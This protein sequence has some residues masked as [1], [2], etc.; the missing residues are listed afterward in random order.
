MT[1]ELLTPATLG[2]PFR[3]AMGGTSNANEQQLDD[4]SNG[5]RRATRAEL[6]MGVSGDGESQQWKTMA[7]LGRNGDG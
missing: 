3:W 4:L 2:N 6:T 5:W 7:M 1:A